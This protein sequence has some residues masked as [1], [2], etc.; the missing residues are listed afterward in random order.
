MTFKGPDARQHTYIAEGYL[1][2]TQVLN[3]AA[4]GTAYV[5]ID[6]DSDGTT[7]SDPAV[8]EFD[9]RYCAPL[10]LAMADAYLGH[11]PLILRFDTDGVSGIEIGAQQIPVNQRGDMMVRFR[12]QPGAMPHVSIVD[13]LSR[14]VPAAALAHKT[15]IMGVTAHA[16]GDRV[17]APVSGDFPG[18]EFQASAI[19][20]VLAGDFIYSSL[21]LTAL[22]RVCAW[23]MGGAA[24]LAAAF[25][26]AL[27]SLLIVLALAAGYFGYTEWELSAHG[28]LIGVIFPT[29]TL[30]ATYLTVVSYRYFAEGREKRF[31]RSAF[32][33][34]V[35]PDYVATLMAA[36]SMLKLGGERRHLSIL[37][38]DIMG[39][40]S[41]AE[42]SQP[43]PLVALLN[44]YMTAMTNVI[45]ATGGVVDKLMGDGIMAFW[46]APLRAKNPACDAIN[47]AIGMMQALNNL[48]AHDSRFNDIHIGI[49]IAT[50]DAIV[51]NFGGEKKFDYS[52]IGDTVNLASRLEGLTRQFKVNI[53]VNQQ[54]YDEAGGDYVSRQVGLVKVKGKDQLVPVVEVAGHRGDGVDPVHYQRFSEAM[55]RLR[56]GQSPEADLRELQREW[57]DDHVTA[58]C[59]ERLHSAKK[60]SLPKEIVF[61]FD[62]K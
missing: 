20:N 22:E 13:V 6:E 58:M 3:S 19:D 47:C 62:T 8:I 54:T 29:V 44:T 15:V 5:D 55:A 49:G 42:R 40:T 23:L 56:Q 61:E 43:E 41:R 27:S 48:A 52:A 26:T 7:R 51:G 33:L 60:T 32:E 37:F 35:H 50:G 45:F 31:I 59:L 38:A 39:F 14:R 46:G 4:R 25:M 57:P 12:G 11:P 1:P 18:V 24:T 30:L 53:L 2:P 21:Y 16:I 10:F 34:Y 28:Q 9:G 36:P 17:V